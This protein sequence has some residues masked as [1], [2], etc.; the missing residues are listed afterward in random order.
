MHVTLLNY[1]FARMCF[2]GLGFARMLAA[3]EQ[4]FAETL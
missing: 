4:S 3:S 2:A 1:A